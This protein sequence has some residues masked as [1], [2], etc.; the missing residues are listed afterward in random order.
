MTVKG[1]IR[2]K[3]IYHMLAYAFDVLKENKYRD[4]GDADENSSTIRIFSQRY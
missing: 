4:L 2:I 1:N 3:N